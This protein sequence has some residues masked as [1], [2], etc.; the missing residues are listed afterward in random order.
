M[1]HYANHGMM[2]VPPSGSG[3][4][5]FTSSSTSTKTTSS[6]IVSQETSVNGNV[7]YSNS[8]QQMMQSASMS[9]RSAA[10][11]P[12]GQMQELDSFSKS[13]E[14]VLNSNGTG[15][16]MLNNANNP[17]NM[18][19]KTNMICKLL[20]N[21]E[22]M[23]REIA[24]LKGENQALRQLTTPYLSMLAILHN[25][26]KV[27]GKVIPHKAGAGLLPGGGSSTSALTVANGNSLAPS[28]GSGGANS[29]LTA[30]SLNNITVPISNDEFEER[31][32]QQEH[33]LSSIL[34]SIHN[35][36]V[37]SSRVYEAVIK[38]SLLQIQTK[39]QNSIQL[40]ERRRSRGLKGEGI[41][42]VYKGGAA[43]GVLVTKSSDS[44]DRASPANSEHSA[45]EGN[46][47]L[48]ILGV[49]DI[50]L[51]ALDLMK[52]TDAS[53]SSASLAI[54][55]DPLTLLLEDDK[56]PL[57]S[58]SSGHLAIKDGSSSSSITNKMPPKHSGSTAA[59]NLNAYRE[60]IGAWSLELV[61]LITAYM[62]EELDGNM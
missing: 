53:S 52:E 2:Q 61:A 33:R 14:M 3:T 35:D 54:T 57:G 16:G 18:S 4:T 5:V 55:D 11:G 28:G 41:A 60:D 56:P 30:L 37:H 9:G 47:L 51:S 39:I 7:T 48:S 15:V 59:N 31:L 40:T 29:S 27:N 44:F 1:A 43:A 25:N 17:N 21:E 8:A 36:T 38:P 45:V 6:Q 10:M 12:N 32:A 46:P 13:A 34:S 58:S 49:L 19:A 62:T 24:Q 26:A 23:R 42:G 50:T 20:A 22:A